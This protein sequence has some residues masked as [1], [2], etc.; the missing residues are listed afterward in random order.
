MGVNAYAFIVTN[1]GYIL[2]HPDYRPVFE[3]I[4]KPAYNRVDMIEVEIM[5]DDSDPRNFNEEILKLRDKVVMQ[6]KGNATLNMKIHLDQKV[7][8]LIL[9]KKKNSLIGVFAPSVT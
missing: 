8:H 6:I 7:Y 3:G 1:N 4:L 2:T 9:N 5:D